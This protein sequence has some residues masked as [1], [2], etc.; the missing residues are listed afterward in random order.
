MSPAMVSKHVMGLERRLGV[1]LLN[2]N[3]H[4]IS[5]T[6]AGRVYYDRCKTILED[7]EETEL[8]LGSLGSAPRGVLRITCPSGFAGRMVADMLAQYR[9]LYPDIV[10]DISFEDRAIDLVEEGY[11]L[12]VRFGSAETLPSGLVARSVQPMSFLIA[13]SRDYVK[14]KGM[15]AS[16]AE[17]DDHDCI[18]LGSQ[19]SW[20]LNSREGRIEVP[21][22]IVQRHRSTAGIPH[23]VAAGIGLA[24]LPSTY[25]ADPVFKATLVPILPEFP[26]RQGMVYLVYI[27]RKY[28]PLK[29]R[30]FIEFFVER[31]LPVY[32]NRAR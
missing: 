19:N 32:E 15:P 14:R 23:A 11:D 9:R 30:T 27:S 31:G 26:V 28:V 6:E 24:P 3:S 25:F 8:E 10:V 16:P 20:I 2:R 29:I 22:R 1:R 13:G 18:A 5:L 7:L 4:A 21:L 12:A 17:L